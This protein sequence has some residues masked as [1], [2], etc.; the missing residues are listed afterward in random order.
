MGVDSLLLLN[1]FYLSIDTRKKDDI[2]YLDSERKLK[3]LSDKV[4]D[5]ANKTGIKY[6]SFNPRSY[7]ASDIVKFNE[8]T[9][10][11]DW[12]SERF[13]HDDIDFIPAST[14]Y[15]GD[16]TSKYHSKYINF[17]GVISYKRN[18]V[19]AVMFC[20]A[21]VYPPL[22]IYYL[23]KSNNYF[24]YFLHLLRIVK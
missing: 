10:L 4:T 3:M 24:Q 13:D 7:S 16:I 8:M 19:P 9:L 12:L 20:F 23:T 18:E 5:N 2:R 21:V 15:L 17:T 14:C 11:N 6:T 1:P 22:L